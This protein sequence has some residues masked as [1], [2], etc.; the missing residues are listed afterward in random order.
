MCWS[1]G[2]STSTYSCAVVLGQLHIGDNSPP[3]KNKAQLLPTRTMIYRTTPHTVAAPRGGGGGQGGNCL[4]LWFFF[5]AACQ[6]SGHGHIPLPHYENLFEIFWKSEEQK[7]MSSSPPPPVGP[8]PHRGWRV[9]PLPQMQITPFCG[10][11]QGHFVKF[12][13]FFTSKQGQNG[14]LKYPYL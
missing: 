6:L 7:N 2:I 12:N 4:P 10:Q 9:W 11:F 8:L 5:F 3:D 14:S 13:P 1:H